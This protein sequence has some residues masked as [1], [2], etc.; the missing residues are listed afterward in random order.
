MAWNEEKNIEKVMKNYLK[1][2]GFNPIGKFRDE[3]LHG[4]DI[5]V[6]NLEKGVRRYWFI[7][8]KGFPSRNY[9]KGKKEGKVK[10]SQTIKAQRYSWLTTAIGQIAMRMKQA[11][12]NYGIA[13]PYNDYYITKVLDSPNNLPDYQKT[14]L[15]IFRSRSKIYFFFI[16]K[17]ADIWQVSPNS[18]KLKLIFKGKGFIGEKR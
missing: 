3:K 15:K 16:T 2:K 1:I 5:C 18:N 11:H 12:G 7:E 9:K 17:N 10:E 8:C 4:V 14:Y 13:L 6:A